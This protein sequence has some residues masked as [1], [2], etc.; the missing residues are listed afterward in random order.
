MAHLD[1]KLRLR[2]AEQLADLKQRFENK[3]A[4]LFFSGTE[5]DKIY[6]GSDGAFIKHRHAVGIG[7]ATWASDAESDEVTGLGDD[8]ELVEVDH[9][10]AIHYRQT[11]SKAP[12]PHYLIKAP[13]VVLN[14][15]GKKVYTDKN[16]YADVEKNRD[17]YWLTQRDAAQ[18]SR[19]SNLRVHFD[20]IAM[21]GRPFYFMEVESKFSNDYSA[22]DIAQA[23]NDLDRIQSEF[24]F[25]PQDVVKS[26]YGKLSRNVALSGLLLE[27]D[28]IDAVPFH[29][30][31][32]FAHSKEEIFTAND[33]LMQ[34]NDANNGAYVILNGQVRVLYQG[35]I[36]DHGKGNILG[37][38]AT[39]NRSNR[40]NATVTALTTVQA[41]HL[42]KELVSELASCDAV[43]YGWSKRYLPGGPA[44]A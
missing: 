30:L 12:S 36:F 34:E 27:N 3:G 23:T 8:H 15:I 17:V 9:S 11:P 33:V 6:Y 24:G 13:T 19:P 35:Q 20:Q 37:E 7:N 5:H 29:C 26:S 42:N 22:R 28:W 38:L 10:W 1:V 44:R 21:K 31:R 18:G 40:R 16:L 2:D 39:C 41:L 43:A 14:G 4:Q 25:K 32:D